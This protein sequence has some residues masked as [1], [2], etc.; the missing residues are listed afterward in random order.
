MSAAAA[1]EARAAAEQAAR[2]KAAVAASAESETV[3]VVVR[4]RPM[5][6]REKNDGRRPV[7]ECNSDLS[8]VTISN[9]DSAALSAEPKSFSF[10]AV[11][12]EM[13]AQKAVYDE[14]AY[15]L[16]ESVL[17]G[18]N[19]TIFAYGQ[20]GCGK[21][22]T[23][24]GRSDPPE[25]RGI[26]PNSFDHVFDH[27]KLATGTEFLVRCSY[28]EIYNEEIRDLLSN[29]HLAKLEL[30]EDP[31]RGVFVKDLTQVVVDTGAAIDK[32]RAGALAPAPA[33]RRWRARARGCAHCGGLPRKRVA[34]SGALTDLFVSFF[35]ARSLSRS[36]SSRARSRPGH[37]RRQQ[38]PH[39]GRDSHERHELA[40][41]LH[42]HRHH[43]DERAQVG[44]RQ[45][46]HQARQAQPRRPRRLGA[47]RQDRSDRHAHEG[48]HQE[49]V[50]AGGARARARARARP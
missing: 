1:A 7:V 28:L 15:P 35:L 23:M 16:V 40:L 41:A 19:G 50:A 6:T 4:C 11:Y 10:D 36:L 47:P 31:D 24:Q 9:P 8:M 33:R 18:Y 39:D 17:A 25:L 45:G 20:T 5:N 43:R 13:S 12:D 14:T 49:R 30:H 2:D 46:A 42:L 48:G 29:D 34:A 44:R 38:A 21:T 32:V 37:E 3:K 27:I 26:I 22:H